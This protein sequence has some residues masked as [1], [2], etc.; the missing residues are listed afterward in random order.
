MWGLE[1]GRGYSCARDPSRF[2]LELLIRPCGS[3]I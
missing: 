1:R 3:V 2:G